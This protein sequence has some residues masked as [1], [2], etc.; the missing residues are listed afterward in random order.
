MLEKYLNEIEPQ[1]IELFKN[2][3][4]G[5]DLNHLKRTMNL[6]L[7]IA[8]REGGDELIVGISAFLHDIHRI[9][10]NSKEFH[11]V[12]PEESIPTI[13][14][15]LEKTDLTEEIKNQICFAIANH[16][17]YNWNKDNVTDINA[18]ILQDA[19][20][21]DA[22]GA[23]GIARA[24]EGGGHYKLPLY[25]DKIPL[26]NNKNFIEG[27]KDPSVLHHF[28]SKLYKL[29]DNMNTKTGKELAKKRISFM[30]NFVQ[31]FLD[32]WNF[33]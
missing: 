33:I 4:T 7:Y 25:D 2:D 16:E 11:Y 29:E 28:Y 13:R 26:N 19:D 6:A 20:N 32:E 5:H 31:E 24:F 3:S 30:K 18:L 9:L 21:M 10:S 1:V 8:K 23:I 14:K 15:I 17:K 12:T 27:A 22:I